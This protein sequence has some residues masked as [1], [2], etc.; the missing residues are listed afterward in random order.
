MRAIIVGEQS[1][2]LLLLP[3]REQDVGEGDRSVPNRRAL[4]AQYGLA[5]CVP[6]DAGQLLEQRAGAVEVAGGPGVHAD[7][8][9]VTP[10]RYGR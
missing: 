6:P 10:H 1:S 2:A 4:L 5:R 8:V 7:G 3:A 9:E